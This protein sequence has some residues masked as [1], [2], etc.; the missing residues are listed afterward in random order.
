MTKVDTCYI[1]GKKVEGTPIF[2]WSDG[3][4]VYDFGDNYDFSANHEKIICDVCGDVVDKFIEF[5]R[6]KVEGV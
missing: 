5:L 6:D 1:C 2:N 4:K 3:Y